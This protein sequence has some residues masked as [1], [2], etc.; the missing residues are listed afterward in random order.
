MINNSRY[1]DK[2][3]EFILS[4]EH[5]TT[6][7]KQESIT[8]ALSDDEITKLVL[9]NIKFQSGFDDV[10]K[11]ELTEKYIKS[12]I[13]YAK[14][15]HNEYNR[16][17]TIYATVLAT[18]TRQY[19]DISRTG[20]PYIQEYQDRVRMIIKVLSADP[21]K[22]MEGD[23]KKTYITTLRNKAE[24]TTRYVAN[25]EDMQEYAKKYKLVW[26]SSHAN[27]SPRC[28]PHQGKLYSLDGSSGVIDGH[29]YVPLAPILKL[30]NGNSILNGYNC[31]HRMIPYKN[32]SFAP[33][34]YSEAEIKREYAIDARM[35]TY[36][37]N[38]RRL[39]METI[40]LRKEGLD[41]S[42][43]IHRYQRLTTQYELFALKN[44]RAYYTWR[45]AISHE[46]KEIL[47]RVRNT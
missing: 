21:P 5:L 1:S 23:A 11:R 40:L 34:E 12:F 8:R 2:G 6:I 46:E 30:N 10:L 15:W 29:R 43:E 9:E 18:N 32:G 33:N 31:R 41:N 36:E 13:T 22:I 27:A 7:I 47:N 26:I 38:I 4:I 19:G 37:N 28:A 39:K 17:K 3:K 35:R 16:S 14:K 44:D 42:A 45:T 25:L 24:M 20:V